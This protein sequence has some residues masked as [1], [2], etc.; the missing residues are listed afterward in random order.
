MGATL[1]LTVQISV[2][3]ARYRAMM[4][5]AHADETQV[6]RKV[7]GNTR[8]SV[9]FGDDGYMFV[10]LGGKVQQIYKSLDG[11]L[12]QVSTVTSCPQRP[13]GQEPG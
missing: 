8:K 11:A 4:L 12:L 3:E 9:C 6:R 5:A 10:R 7:D 1:Q 2:T 13:P